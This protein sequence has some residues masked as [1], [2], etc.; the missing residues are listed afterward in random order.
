MA[1]LGGLDWGTLKPAFRHAVGCK[2][3]RGTGYR[4]R[5]VIAETLVLTPEIG[6]ALRDGASTEKLQAIAV[7]Q[8]MRTLAADGIRRAAK[9]ETTLDEVIRVTRGI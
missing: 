9:G 5:T 3:C 7:S 1:A 4:G 8:G 6:R 2:L